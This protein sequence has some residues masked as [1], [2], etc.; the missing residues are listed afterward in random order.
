MWPIVPT[1]TCGLSRVNFSF[2]IVQVSL[3]AGWTMKLLSGNCFLS[4][5]FFDDLVGNALRH[6][7]VMRKLHR[8]NRAPLRHRSQRRGITEHLGE[9]HPRLDHLGVLA[10][11]QSFDLPAAR[12][13]IAHDVSH[14]LLRRPALP[15]PYSL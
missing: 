10:G 5:D 12:A 3:R 9:R 11:G 14:V 1:L 8:E 13:Q 4:F 7:L 2:A 15:L 6:L